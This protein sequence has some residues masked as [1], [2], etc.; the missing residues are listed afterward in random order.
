MKIAGWV[1]D[2]VVCACM[3]TGARRVD[4]A[5]LIELREL[6]TR[7]AGPAHFRGEHGFAR[8]EGNEASQHGGT[9]SLPAIEPGLRTPPAGG[10]GRSG[11]AKGASMLAQILMQAAG[12]VV[13]GLGD[14]QH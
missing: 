11:A 8:E 12:L 1:V 10:A 14:D 13:E 9:G 5:A 2:P 6:V 3:T 7:V 4:L